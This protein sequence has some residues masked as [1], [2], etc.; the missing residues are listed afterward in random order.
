VGEEARDEGALALANGMLNCT[1]ASFGQGLG[2]T[3]IVDN[4]SC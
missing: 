3:W 2:F 1:G 4:V